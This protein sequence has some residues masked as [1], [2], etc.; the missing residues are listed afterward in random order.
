LIEE[1]SQIEQHKRLAQEL[2]VFGDDDEDDG[3]KKHN[4][5]DPHLGWE[6]EVFHNMKIINALGN[7]LS[8][9]VWP[10]YID[11]NNKLNYSMQINLQ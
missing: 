4:K 6:D 1:E 8:P 9:T 5:E 3:F 11:V 10:R 2:N 7:Q